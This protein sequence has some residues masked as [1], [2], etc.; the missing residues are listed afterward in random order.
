MSIIQ[1]INGIHIHNTL[2]LMKE[3]GTI[4]TRGGVTSSTSS[5]ARTGEEGEEEEEENEGEEIL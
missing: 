2:G 3:L 4:K 5:E 1:C